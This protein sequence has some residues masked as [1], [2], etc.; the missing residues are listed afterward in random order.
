MIT[1]ELKVKTRSSRNCI[2]KNEDGT[3]TAYLTQAPV[4]GKA[5]RCLIKLLSEE[6]GVVKSSIR[7]VKGLHSKNK[8]ISIGV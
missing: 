2:V 8:S 1:I 7:I 4:E 3:Y 5:N 6:F